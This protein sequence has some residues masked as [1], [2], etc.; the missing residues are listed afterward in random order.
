MNFLNYSR[1]M[2]LPLLTLMA[3]PAFADIFKCKGIAG[4]IAYQD[5]PCSVGTETVIGPRRKPPESTEATT[6]RLSKEIDDELARRSRRAQAYAEKLRPQQEA[7]AKAH[8]TENRDALAK[9]NKAQEQQKSDL[10]SCV[11][12]DEALSCTASRY[13]TLLAGMHRSDIEDVLG[14]ARTQRV[15]GVELLYY[16]VPVFEGRS[17][18]SGRLQLSFGMPS[19][20]PE[21]ARGRTNRV[22]EVNVY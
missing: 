10:R 15:G 22:T 3:P 2:A 5:T 6:A 17:W 8:E 14:D 4:Q 19:N 20:I 21:G 9:F 7:Y 13:G 1:L 11:R 16:G 12:K 18:R